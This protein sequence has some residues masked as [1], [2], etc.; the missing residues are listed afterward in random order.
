MRASLVGSPTLAGPALAATAVPALVREARA[1]AMLTGQW[2]KGEVAQH[3]LPHEATAA[4]VCQ[5]TG[6][7]HFDLHCLDWSTAVAAVR[8]TSLS[9]SIS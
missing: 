6:Q 9:C 7:C 8:S 1:D 3:A 4:V 5:S 2:Q